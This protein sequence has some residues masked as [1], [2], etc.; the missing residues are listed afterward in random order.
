MNSVRVH[1]KAPLH[2]AAMKGEAAA[3]ELLLESGAIIDQG[4]ER[5]QTPAHLAAYYGRSDLLSMLAAKGASLTARS[6]DGWSMVHFAAAGGNPDTIK[7]LLEGGA[8]VNEASCADSAS[9]AKITPLHLAALRGSSAAVSTLL[10]RG[11]DPSARAAGGSTPIDL[12]MPVHSDLA[13][14]MRRGTVA[15]TR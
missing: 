10:A 2:F 15:S 3:A 1:G 8:N 9:C 6:K 5:G 12:A 13:D 7:F 14:L 4:D 11:A